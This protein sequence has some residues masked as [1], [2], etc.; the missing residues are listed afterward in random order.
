MSNIKHCDKENK[1][2][3]YIKQYAYGGISG[4]F[5]I[6]LSHPLDTIKTHIQ[7][8][9]PLSSLSLSSSLSKAN[10]LSRLYRGLSIPLIGVGFEKAIVFGTYNYML[11]QTDSIAISGAISGLSASLIV[12]PYERLKILR[13]NSQTYMTKDI[14]NPRF[15]FKGLSA[16]FTREV[17][18]FAIYFSVYEKL[19]YHT[20]TKYGNNIT[21]IASFIYGGCSG[22]VAWVFIYPQDKIKTVMQSSVQSTYSQIIRN[23]YT[24]YGI[25]YFYKGFSWAAGRAMLLHS[26]TFYMMEVL[27][28]I[29]YE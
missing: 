5:G 24:S 6:L 17:P 25:T 2:R 10:N 21:G 28:D 11:K 3:H 26:G 18:G 1:T 9:K 20:F 4:I 12:S 8:G 23:M 7:N 19:K 29:N 14:M 16:T 22:L 27:N 13:Q 15:L